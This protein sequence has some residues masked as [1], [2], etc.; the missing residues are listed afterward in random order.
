V[1]VGL[2]NIE[3]KVVNTAYMQIAKYHRDRGDT[4]EWWLPLEDEA[5]D[6]VYCSSIFRF[7]NKSE[8]PERAICGGTGFEDASSLDM[9]VRYDYSLYP[10]CD[11]SIVRFSRGCI[12]KCPFCLVPTVEGGIRSVEPANL[13]PN[14]KTIHVYDNNFFANREWPKAIEQLRAWGQSVDFQG[15]DVRL[16]TREQCEALLSLKHHKQI[17]IA[18]DNPQANLTDCLWRAAQWLRAWRLMCYVLIGYDSSH[19]QDLF[20][21]KRIASLG[22]DPF[23]M[24][25]NKRDPYQKRF[26]RWV[27][28]KAIFKMTEWK[29]YI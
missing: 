1:R 26:A 22:I 12:R 2:I 17:K 3:P 7:T 16:L 19:E 14:G 28:H 11:Y 25:Y 23:V 13:N 9:P 29:D 27:N 20:R 10:E 8:I 15:V 24:P 21:V 4:V 6:K 18:W 5:F